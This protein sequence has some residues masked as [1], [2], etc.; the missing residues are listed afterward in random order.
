MRDYAE[1]WEM[2]SDNG[3]VLLI[4]GFFVTPLKSMGARHIRI[5]ILEFLSL[6][7]SVGETVGR[8]RSAH[9]S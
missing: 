1:L 4:R 3:V 7:E 9:L 8:I 2:P 5:A 6:L